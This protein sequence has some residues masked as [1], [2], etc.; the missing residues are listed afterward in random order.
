LPCLVASLAIVR[1]TGS[2]PRA[3]CTKVV[4]CLL[5]GEQG[6]KGRCHLLGELTG[7]VGG[8]VAAGAG[9]RVQAE[10]AAPFDPLVVL[11]GEDRSDEPNPGGAVR[12]DS[13]HIGCPAD[14][15]MEVLPRIVRPDLLGECGEHANRSGRAAS[16]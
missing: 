8:I 11:F 14:F 7:A 12:E 1:L 4:V 10:I 13:N 9:Q 15:L 3:W 5:V 2:S 6:S 16:R